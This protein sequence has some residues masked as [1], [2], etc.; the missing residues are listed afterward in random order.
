M[1]ISNDV[2]STTENEFDTEDLDPRI[3]VSESYFFC[4]GCFF[5]SWNINFYHFVENL[6]AI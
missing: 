6:K 2:V 4:T 5:K 3:Q 1:S